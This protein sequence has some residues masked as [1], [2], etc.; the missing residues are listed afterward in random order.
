M[1]AFDVWSI[2]LRTELLLLPRPL[3]LYNDVIGG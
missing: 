3:F 2:V 1:E